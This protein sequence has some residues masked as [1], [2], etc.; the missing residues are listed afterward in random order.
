MFD[1]LS[2]AR[3]DWAMKEQIIEKKNLILGA[4]VVLAVI[5]GIALNQK[6]FKTTE[7]VSPISPAS[8][9]APIDP[10]T[11]GKVVRDTVSGKDFISNQIIVEFN[12]TVSEEEAL[13]V[14]SG[15]GGKMEQRFT[16]VPLFLMRVDDAGDGVLA[17]SVVKKLAADSRVKRAELNFLT[18]N[19]TAN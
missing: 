16:A 9:P 15:V 13:A 3:Y 18:T 5:I 12:V 8:I 7:S 2:L 6:I 1:S 19:K 10:K 4:G 11:I 14:I 17:R